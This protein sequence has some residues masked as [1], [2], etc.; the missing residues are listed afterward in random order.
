MTEASLRN[1]QVQIYYLF[2]VHIASQLS[3]CPPSSSSQRRER[4]WCHRVMRADLHGLVQSNRVTRD[5]DD[6][7]V[8]SWLSLFYLISK[9]W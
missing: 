5:R 3:N 4:R 7:L 9:I 6:I 8:L 2:T 1:K